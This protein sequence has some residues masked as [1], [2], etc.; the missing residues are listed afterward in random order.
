MSQQ[1]VDYHKEQKRN[2]QKIMKKEK[3]IR[4]LQFAVF[5]IVLVALVAWFS[6]LIYKNVQAK[7]SAGAA[8]EATEV[9]LSAWENYMNEMDG[10]VHPEEAAAETEAEE[11]TETE[12][13]SGT[14]TTEVVEVEEE[15]KE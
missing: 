11:S 7:N 14:E 12:K 15:S 3:A 2:R 5:I 10:L 8:V 9:D 6:Y 1:K 13:E 4:R